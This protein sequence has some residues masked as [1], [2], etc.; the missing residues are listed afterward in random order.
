MLIVLGFDFEE[1]LGVEAGGA[2][3]GGLVT[4]VDEAAVAAF[5]DGGAFGFEDFVG[6]DVF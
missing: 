5:P 2:V 1:G 6:F 4:C 3:V